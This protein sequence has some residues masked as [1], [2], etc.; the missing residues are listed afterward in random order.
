MPRKARVTE[1]KQAESCG[2]VNIFL[3]KV[4]CITNIVQLIAGLTGVAK[5]LP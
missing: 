5:V 4:M 2:L 1:L 3:I